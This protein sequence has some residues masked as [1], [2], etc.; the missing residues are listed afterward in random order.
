M[1]NAG[2]PHSYQLL[3]DFF[4]KRLY[5][6]LYLNILVFILLIFRYL[7]FLLCTK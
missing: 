6:E 2:F 5:S 7:H 3:R 1:L 4:V